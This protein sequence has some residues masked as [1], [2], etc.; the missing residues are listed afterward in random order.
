[1]KLVIVE[2]PT[3]KITGILDRYMICL[4][5]HIYV[6]N[7]INVRLFGMIKDY[8]KTQTKNLTKVIFV[9]EDYN[10]ELKLKIEYINYSSIELKNM[11]GFFLPFNLAS[12]VSIVL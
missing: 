7:I 9:E 1:M 5:S 4:M 10:S 6:S 2:N 12:P 8:I 11:E 3:G